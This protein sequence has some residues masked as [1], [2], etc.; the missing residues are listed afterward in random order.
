MTDDRLL[1]QKKWKRLREFVL[2]RDQYLDQELKRYGKRREARYV[3][4]IF[5]REFFPQWTYEEWNLISLSQETHNM[6]HDRTGHFLTE[7]GWSLLLR[8]AR[9]NKIEVEPFW[10]E[11]VVKPS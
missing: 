6:M 5:P 1:D 2:A 4:H 3:H 10:R 8:T 9:K 7:S 11:M